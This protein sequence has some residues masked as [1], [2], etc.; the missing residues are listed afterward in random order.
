MQSA[1]PEVRVLCFWYFSG[2]LTF[3]AS[4][5]PRACGAE[6]ELNSKICQSINQV[7]CMYVG[8]LVSTCVHMYTPMIIL[9][10]YPHACGHKLQSTLFDDLGNCATG[11]PPAHLEASIMS[12]TAS[13]RAP[14][15]KVTSH[16]S[17]KFKDPGP[18]HHDAHDADANFPN[19]HVGSLVRTCPALFRACRHR[20][21]PQ[22]T[23]KRRESISPCTFHEH[24]VQ[25]QPS[26]ACQRASIV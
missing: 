24:F 20:L 11:W 22:P 25:W 16:C 23:A 9:Y 5:S 6:D 2:E 7:V 8:L 19:H 18:E 26:L 10:E 12:I 3:L 13:L 17:P 1:G 15:V 21:A 14:V 4:S